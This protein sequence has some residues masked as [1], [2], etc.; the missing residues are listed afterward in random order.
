MRL[1]VAKSASR[2]AI[3]NCER[4]L[5]IFSVVVLTVCKMSFSC[6]HFLSIT[7]AFAR[8]SAICS[9]ISSL[10]ILAWSDLSFF[11]AA[12]SI[13]NCKRLLFNRS[14]AIG[15]LSNCI[16]SELVASSS[17]STALSGK[18]RS[19]KY[20]VDNLAAATIASSAIFTP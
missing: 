5:S 20:L 15:T 1:A 8:I 13:S 9:L 7:S 17:K 19:G 4:R 3:S 10:R 16:L 12:S 11:N 18:N 6:C 2:S 14:S